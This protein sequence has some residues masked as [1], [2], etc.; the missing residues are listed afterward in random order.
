LAVS[1][2][3]HSQ[4]KG[5]RKPDDWLGA[6]GRA[7]HPWSAAGTEQG[8]LFAA[9]RTKVGARFIVPSASEVAVK[10]RPYPRPPC[11]GRTADRGRSA[12]PDAGGSG[13][14]LAV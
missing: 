1:G 14:P 11:V 4:A 7:D 12:L 13:W 6:T 10:P 8:Q 5:D 9:G 2:W 3:E